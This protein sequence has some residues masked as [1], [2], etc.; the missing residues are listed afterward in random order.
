MV[1]R[2]VSCQSGPG[3]DERAGG[4][5]GE[6]TEARGWGV[7]LTREGERI[8]PGSMRV[9]RFIGRLGVVSLPAVEVGLDLDERVVRRHVAKLEAAGWLGRA[10]W[11]WGKGSVAWLTGRGLGGTALGGLQPLKLP[12]APG[13]VDHAVA[14]GWTAARVERRGRRWKSARELALDPGR[15]AARIRDDR[16]ASHDRVPDLA[17][18]MPDAEL[19]IA[20]IVE[21]GHRRDDRQR[22]ILEGWRD[23]VDA[24]RY[25][26]IRY[27][28]AS[29]SVAQRMKRLADKLWLRGPKFL[30]AAQLTG[31]EIIELICADQQPVEPSSRGAPLPVQLSV[32]PFARHDEA[33]ERR[34]PTPMPEPVATRARPVREPESPEAA[35]ERERLYWQVMGIPDPKPRRRWR[36]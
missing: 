33:D 23:A 16:G 18:W 6:A 24:G 29:A 1:V 10:P 31:D 36:R 8:G 35:A 32:V 20:V 22:R 34:P 3:F 11:I 17:V 27:D 14:V 28:C 7:R 4:A 30:A 15:W 13:T 12:P 19:P 21:N 26:S 5:D 2:V 9:G 25:A